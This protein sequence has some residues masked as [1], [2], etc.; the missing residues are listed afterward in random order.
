VLAVDLV[1]DLT[2]DSRRGV[3][4][5]DAP[6]AEPRGD[7]RTR[8][9]DQWREPGAR[10]GADLV[11]AEMIRA[12]TADPFEWFHGKLRVVLA[13]IAQELAPADGAAPHPSEA[14]KTGPS[15]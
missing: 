13:G 7:M 14:P 4:T 3:E 9:E 10:G 2:A 15:A 5:L 12:I 11:H 1:F 6:G 8:I